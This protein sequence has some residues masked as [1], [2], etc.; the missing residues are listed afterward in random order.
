M[1]LHQPAPQPMVPRVI[2]PSPVKHSESVFEFLDN[3]T[4]I[5]TADAAVAHILHCY[6]KHVIH[7]AMSL[8]D[9]EEQHDLFA[10][11]HTKCN[12]LIEFS[13]LRILLEE[14]LN[15]YRPH[16]CAL[17]SEERDEVV[18]SC[19]AWLT[20]HGDMFLDEHYNHDANKVAQAT[21]ARLLSSSV[22]ELGAA[23]TA[24]AT[25]GAY[26]VN[27]SVPFQKF[28]RWFLTTAA[29][30]DRYR[31]AESAQADAIGASVDAADVR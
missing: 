31:D 26:S 17:S 18:D 5:T 20:K 11:D 16:N 30:V 4:L 8:V 13:D 23:S 2:P 19:Y 3:H 1:H 29:A 12:V 24:P 15:V 25:A 21:M 10:K 28:R 9:P 7:H 14:A 27:F 6:R 22:V